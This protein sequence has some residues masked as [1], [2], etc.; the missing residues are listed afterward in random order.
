[1]RKV[2]IRKDLVPVPASEMNEYEGGRVINRMVRKIS[3]ALFKVSVDPTKVLKGPYLGIYCKLEPW[4]RPTAPGMYAYIRTE[5]PPWV[6]VVLKRLI[7]TGFA[8]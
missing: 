3:G 5:N 6:E 4:G 2:E 8:Y 1:M 7:L